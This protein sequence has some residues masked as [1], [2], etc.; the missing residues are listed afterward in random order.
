[1]DIEI[2]ASESCLK[3]MV[4]EVKKRISSEQKYFPWSLILKS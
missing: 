3:V 4:N 2:N 1:M